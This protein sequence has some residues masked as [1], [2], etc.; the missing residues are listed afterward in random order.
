ME[1]WK[2]IEGFSDYSVSDLGRVR[3]S[4]PGRTARGREDGIL[5]VCVHND[6]YCLVYMTND[7][8]K[9]KGRLISRLVA[10]A[11]LENP[12]SLPEV[13]HK[14]CDKSNNRLDNL[15][16]VTAKQNSIHASENGRMHNKLSAGAVR[17]IRAMR[18]LGRFKLSELAEMFGTTDRNIHSICHKKSYAWLS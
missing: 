17:L 12:A 18:S 13:N 8:G 2:T 9:R 10:G 14:D 16:W 6:G 3:S 4:R 5:S 11:F 1:N 15:E 7:C